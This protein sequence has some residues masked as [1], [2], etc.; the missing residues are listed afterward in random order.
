MISISVII[1]I[2]NTQASLLKE[3]L[4]SVLNQTLKNIEIIIIDDKSNINYETELKDYIENPQIILYKNDKN[5]GSGAARNKGI[6]IAKGEYIAFL[7]ADD[8]YTNNDA[9]RNLYDI[10]KCTL[11]KIVGGKPFT[12]RETT[13]EPLT[14]SY[15]NADKLY[16]NQILNYKEAQICYGYW[17]YIYKRSFLIKNN[18]YFNNLKRFQDPLWFY[19][20]L[21]TSKKYFSSDI[22]FY[23]HRERKLLDFSWTEE[24][25][26]DYF[27][28]F[29][30]LVQQTNSDKNY[31]LHEYLYRKA[32]N[33]EFKLYINAREELGV[34]M[35]N[36]L[37]S[38][39]NSF[40]FEKIKDLPIFKSVADLNNIN[41]E[42]LTKFDY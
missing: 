39:L 41:F 7:D 14:W 10:A 9:L 23:A 32:L 22:P 34:N 16:Q 1:P 4:D 35:S 38:L 8:F 20:A 36:E 3:A 29:T 30:Q 5:E 12:Q 26:K 28:G 24:S 18:L 37:E 19:N 25:L 21:T 15:K 27:K 31:D 2:Y 6:H 11:Q 42:E 17:N 40:N 13:I 33:W